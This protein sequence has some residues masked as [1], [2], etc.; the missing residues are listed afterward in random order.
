MLKP[1][2]TFKLSK[3]TKT[4]LASIVDPRKRSEWKRAMIDAELCAA[5]VP[6]TIKKE[7]RPGSNYNTTSTSATA[8]E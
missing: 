1:N 2:K 5:I 6:K 3:P 8:A 4:M 7:N